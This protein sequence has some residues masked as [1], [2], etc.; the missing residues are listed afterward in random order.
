MSPN[1]AP[2]SFPPPEAAASGRGPVGKRRGNGSSPHWNVGRPALPLSG[3]FA[4]GEEAR[5]VDLGRPDF[6]ILGGL[7]IILRQQFATDR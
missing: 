2:A 3:P 4:L 1:P 7:V 6:E 5:G